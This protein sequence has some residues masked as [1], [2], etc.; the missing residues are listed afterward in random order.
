MS[1]VRQKRKFNPYAKG[2]QVKM[3][4]K[5]RW[6]DKTPIRQ[7][8]GTDSRTDMS[9]SKQDCDIGGVRP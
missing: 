6:K 4:H 5:D 7:S 1:A 2:T 3:Y 9:D 8:Q